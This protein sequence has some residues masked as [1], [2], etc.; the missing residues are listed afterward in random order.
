MKNISIKVLLL[1]CV[2]FTYSSCI[3]DP[4]EIL[5]PNGAIPAVSAITD[6]FYDLLNTSSV[7]PSFMLDVSGV[8]VS[9]V[10]VL[11]S[12]NGSAPVSHATISSF[13]TTISI[14]FNEMASGLPVDVNNLAVG[15]QFDVTFVC[16]TSDG[17]ALTSSTKVSV[18]VSCVSALAGMY[19][20]TTTYGYHDFLPDFNPHTATAEIVEVSAGIYEIAD[21]SG[22]LYS[23]GPY[24]SAYGTTG[25]PAQFSDICGDISW[26]GQSDPWGAMV[27]DPDGTNSVDPATGVITISW[28]CEGYGENG[29][30]IYTPQ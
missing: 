27:Q 9:N 17:R 6:G 1:F 4:D 22:G 10:T 7:T 11:K 14:P 21:F 24:S 19:D 8:G 16:N 12:F 20:V 28:L 15:D 3:E 30:S 18:P 23:T 26:T 25:L 13:P 2:I 5:E 29:V